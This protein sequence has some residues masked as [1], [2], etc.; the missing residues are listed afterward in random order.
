MIM[1]EGLKNFNVTIKRFKTK[2]MNEVEVI[3]KMSKNI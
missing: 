3:L 1:I 2:W